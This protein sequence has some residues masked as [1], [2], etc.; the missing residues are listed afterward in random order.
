[1]NRTH[2]IETFSRKP[3]LKRRQ[4]YFRIVRID[5]GQVVAQSEGVNN[6]LDRNRTVSAL[7]LGRPMQVVEVE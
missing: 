6:A 4:Y 5:N 3:L 2:R 1:M 7:S